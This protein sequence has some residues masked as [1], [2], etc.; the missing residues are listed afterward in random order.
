MAEVMINNKSPK[1]NFQA[2]IDYYYRN[3]EQILKR[4]K[5][6][7]QQKITCACGCVIKIQTKSTHE[8]T[9]KHQLLM[10]IK[11]LTD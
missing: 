6:Y 3:K 10:K 7:T 11:E 1:S 5:E 8:R 2:Q 9:Q 4:Q